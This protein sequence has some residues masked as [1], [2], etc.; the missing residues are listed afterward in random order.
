V[1]YASGGDD[2]AQ[3]A[4]HVAEQTRATLERAKG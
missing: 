3:A 1:L 4:R 2:F